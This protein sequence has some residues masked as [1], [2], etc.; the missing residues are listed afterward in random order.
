MY[1]ELVL[2]SHEYMRNIIEVDPKWMFEIAPHFYAVADFKAK[3]S[4]GG[5][6]IEVE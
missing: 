1:H 3:D 4:K 2:T 5:D 6:P